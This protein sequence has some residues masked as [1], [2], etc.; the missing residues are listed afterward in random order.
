[1][2]IFAAAIVAIGCIIYISTLERNILLEYY[3]F[4]WDTLTLVMEIV[5]TCVDHVKQTSD[6]DVASIKDYM[7]FLSRRVQKRENR[8]P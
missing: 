8:Q 1:M 2:F 3:S 5:W 7:H 4:W 6:S